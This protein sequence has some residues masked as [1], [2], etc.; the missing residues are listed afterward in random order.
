MERPNGR[1]RVHDEPVLTIPYQFEVQLKKGVDIG[2]TVLDAQGR[3]LA[4]VKVKA[5][6]GVY[7][8]RKTE[9]HYSPDKTVETDKDGKWN[10][11]GASENLSQTHLVYT[12]PGYRSVRSTVKIAKSRSRATMLR[13]VTFVDAET[14]IPRSNPPALLPDTS[15]PSSVTLV[16]EFRMIP[17]R[18]SVTLMSNVG[19]AVRVMSLNSL[20]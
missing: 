8:F 10:I 16:A 4:G 13:S 3:P 7:D 12:L 5:H 17:P 9:K 20:N 19:P 18:A 14:P 11:Q 2:G 1:G 6:L 15:N